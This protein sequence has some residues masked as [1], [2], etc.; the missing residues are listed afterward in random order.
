MI[1]LNLSQAPAPHPDIPALPSNW[2]T[3]WRT[4]PFL[5]LALSI[6]TLSAD[7]TV[8]NAAA[9]TPL[10]APGII[11]LEPTARGSRAFYF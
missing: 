3:H 2:R 8:L 5:H 6:L 4:H 10:E 9:E 11:I 7:T 1:Q